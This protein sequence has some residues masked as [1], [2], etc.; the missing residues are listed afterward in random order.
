MDV[1][2][3]QLT[4]NQ[5]ISGVNKHALF[6]EALKSFLVAWIIH[7]TVM[8]NAISYSYLSQNIIFLNNCHNA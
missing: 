7:I 6:R 2:S 8:Y 3:S 5:H 4:F 1:F